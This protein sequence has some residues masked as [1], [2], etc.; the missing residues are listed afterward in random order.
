[1]K[2][3]GGGLRF[4]EG[5]KQWKL[6]PF[7][8][9]GPIIDVMMYGANKYAPRNWERGMDWSISFDCLMRHMTAWF[10]GEEKDPESGCSHL[11]HAGCNILFLLAYSVRGIG[12]DDRPKAEPEVG[13]RVSADNL[14]VCGTPNRREDVFSVRIKEAIGHV[15]RGFPHLLGLGEQMQALQPDSEERELREVQGEAS[16][17]DASQACVYDP[18]AEN[19]LWDSGLAGGSE[20][21]APEV[22]SADWRK[23]FT[24]SIE[25]LRRQT[26]A[27]PSLAALTLRDRPRLQR[28]QEII[29]QLHDALRSVQEQWIQ[30]GFGPVPLAEGSGEQDE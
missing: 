9:L 8:A 17:G 2:V 29:A 5:K 20:T 24:D 26:K 18:R 10:H 13:A 11:G 3:D 14:L 23:S 30:E 27:C 25:E 19:S 21:K 28:A 7:D 12:N 4:N 6:L 16:S 22:R 1:M 15:Q